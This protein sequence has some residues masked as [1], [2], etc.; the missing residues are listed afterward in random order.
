MS[1]I[2][3][4]LV[5]DSVPDAHM[6]ERIVQKQAISKG[7]KWLKDGEEAID[8]LAHN[9]LNSTCFIL[10]DIKLPKISGLE[11]LKVVR[12][13]EKTSHLPIVMYSSSKE[14]EDIKRAYLNG[15]N[16]YIIKP[17]DFSNLKS[18]LKQLTTYWLKLNKVSK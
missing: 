8:F 3:F 6:I 1:K 9:E 12:A 13:N 7:Y 14:E 11:V 16:S 4:L 10:L 2:D 17:L 5:E 18:T 15:A